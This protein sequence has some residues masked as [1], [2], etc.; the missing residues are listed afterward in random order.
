MK[1]VL[2]LAP[3]ILLFSAFGCK[4]VVEDIKRNYVLDIMTKGRWYVELFNEGSTDVTA[5]FA[6]YEF[7]F[8]ENGKVD[9]IK[10]TTTQQGTWAAD[11]SAL[12]IT[13][14]FP[15]AV[16]PL[17]KLNAVWKLTDSYPDLVVAQTVVGT[18]TH[19]LKLRKK[20]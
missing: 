11:V 10:S 18:E 15:S 20:P 16:A 7:Q 13:S 17:Q 3:I 5:D 4:K 12:T 2:L 19:Y 1:K 9:G 6:G 8:Y 14:N